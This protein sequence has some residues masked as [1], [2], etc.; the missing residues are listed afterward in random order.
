MASATRKLERLKALV[1]YPYSA[2]A[3][4]LVRI[5]VVIKAVRAGRNLDGAYTIKSL[6]KRFFTRSL[7]SHV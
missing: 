1:Q 7:L 3:S 4:N 5:G 2:G 6:T